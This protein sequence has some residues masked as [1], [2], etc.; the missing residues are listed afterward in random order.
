MLSFNVAQLLKEGIGASRQYALSGDLSDID[1]ENPGPAQVQGEV[2]LVRTPRGILA[3]GQAESTLRQA[4]RRCLQVADAAVTLEIEEEFIPS[5]DV[6]TGASLPITDED[7]RELVIDAHH[8]LDVT[9]VLRQLAVAALVS[10]G[11]CREDCQGLC[12]VCGANLN[13]ETCECHTQTVDP[14][15]AILAQLLGPQDNR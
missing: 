2:Y 1:G 8:I 6:E 7:E 3:Q 13:V 4:C 10:P 15:L 12:P 5:M 14:R 9:E 11:L